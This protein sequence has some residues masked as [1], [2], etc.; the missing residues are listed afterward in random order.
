MTNPDLEWYTEI[1]AAKN[2]P[3][4]CPF[5]SVQRCPR[6]YQSISLLGEW[7]IATKVDPE[8][9]QQLLERWRRSDL[10]PAV[11]EEAT[12]IMGP[13]RKARHFLN[14]CPEVAFNTLSWFASHLSVHADEIDADVAHKRLA[15]EGAGL[16][17]WRWHWGHVTPMHYS[18][19]PVYSPLLLG[20]SQ[21]KSKGTIGFRIK[22]D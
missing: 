5:A 7:G 15:C 10:W 18:N 19:C 22:D 16:R 21:R 9:D 14:F 17:D 20:E 11:A 2:L 3:P 12:A 4:R 1:S 6:Y 8:E 13:E